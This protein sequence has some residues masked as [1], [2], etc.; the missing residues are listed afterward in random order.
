MTKGLS[1]R[2]TASILQAY[3]RFGK[4]SDQDLIDSWPKDLDDRFSV[5]RAVLVDRSPLSDELQS[6]LLEQMPL[7]SPKSQEL[8]IRIAIKKDL[9]DA[10]I[11]RFF[12]KSTLTEVTKTSLKNQQHERTR[13]LESLAS[14]RQGMIDNVVL[15]REAW[16]E[17]AIRKAIQQN[18]PDI[19]DWRYRMKDP[20]FRYFDSA[21]TIGQIEALPNVVLKYF[22]DEKGKTQADDRLALIHRAQDACKRKGLTHLRMP[23]A[24]RVHEL[25]DKDGKT[26]PV[27]LVVEELL[28]IAGHSFN[29]VKDLLEGIN[30]DPKT[31]R[32][33]NGYFSELTSLVCETGLTDLK[34]TNTPL[35]K[36][37]SGLAIVDSNMQHST[38][39]SSLY[40]F[41]QEDHSLIDWLEPQ[42]FE[43][44]G[45]A[46]ENDPACP[47]GIDRKSYEKTRENSYKLHKEI[48]RFHL[49]EYGGDLSAPITL[50]A[51][52]IEKIDPNTRELCLNV[53]NLINQRMPSN[54]RKIVVS[55]SDWASAASTP[56]RVWHVPDATRMKVVWELK[57]L[58]KIKD[59]K[60]FG[61]VYGISFQ[62]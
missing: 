23:N 26:V 54:R 1:S 30:Q 53:V 17:E 22:M 25:K 14:L 6:F 7:F 16:D 9:P 27:Q 49:F 33:V 43:A 35:L 51:Q 3:L 11:Q 29:E 45:Q 13:H 41:G 61:G 42:N 58:G 62:A 2:E 59:F 24:F 34:P 46:L 57:K 15:H 31:L 52:E 56:Y 28:P 40:Q 19:L 39:E 47:K 5:F 10:V 44:V 21:D 18:G 48:R 55:G 37:G 32:I 8:A 12:D 20:R 50:T 36:D 38:P 60:N 4:L